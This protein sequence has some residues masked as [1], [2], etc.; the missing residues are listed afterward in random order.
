MSTET[1]RNSPVESFKDRLNDGKRQGDNIAEEERGRLLA[2]LGSSNERIN[3][4]GGRAI[5]SCETADPAAE[6][7]AT[8]VALH[9][10][11]H[12]AHLG[13]NKVAPTTFG[14]VNL[15]CFRVAFVANVKRLSMIGSFAAAWSVAAAAATAVSATSR[16]LMLRFPSSALATNF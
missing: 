11:I 16:P 13:Q 7:A 4:G 9:P 6:A 2:D 1:L 3:G 12:C 14:N 15:K 5:S 10:S 8:E